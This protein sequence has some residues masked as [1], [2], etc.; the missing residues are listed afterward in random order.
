MRDLGWMSSTEPLLKLSPSLESI[1]AS[2]KQTLLKNLLRL[3]KMPKIFIHGA[4]K[5]NDVVNA[6]H[7]EEQWEQQEMVFDKV[8]KQACLP[9][10]GYLAIIN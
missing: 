10:M 5:L 2:L 9:A 6:D 1:E 8:F 3:K 4:N 7:I